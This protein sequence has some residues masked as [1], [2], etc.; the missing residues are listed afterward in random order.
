MNL[1]KRIS[2]VLAVIF[3]FNMIGFQTSF[4]ENASEA[5]MAPQEQAET[6]IA[7][8]GEEL[9]QVE[10]ENEELDNDTISETNTTL[11]FTEDEDIVQLIVNPDE[12]SG[13]IYFVS[14]GDQ[15]VECSED[16]VAIFYNVV[17]G[18]YSVNVRK[19]GADMPNLLASDANLSLSAAVA[20]NRIIEADDA[21]TKTYILYANDEAYY[22]EYYTYYYNSEKELRAGDSITLISGAGVYYDDVKISGFPGTITFNYGGYNTPAAGCVTSITGVIG[23]GY[24]GGAHDFSISASVVDYG[25]SESGGGLGSL[26]NATFN[27]RV[28]IYS[29]F[30]PT[31]TSAPRPTPRPTATP[32]PTPTPDAVVRLSPIDDAQIFNE[33]SNTNKNYGS[34]EYGTAKSEISD[35]VISGRCILY[36]FDLLQVPSEGIT[37]A[38][39]HIFHRWGAGGTSFKVGVLPDGDFNNN[40]NESSITYDEF[41]ESGIDFNDVE[42]IYTGNTTATNPYVPV[43]HKIPVADCLNSEKCK[44]K[45]YVTFVVYNEY[46]PQNGIDFT[47]KEW[48]GGGEDSTN[49]PNTP[50]AYRPT[51]SVNYNYSMQANLDWISDYFRP[52]RAIM[53]DIDLPSETDLG[54]SVTWSTSNASRL[55]NN[56]QVSRPG[57]Y[58]KDAVVTLTAHLTLADGET[59]EKEVT[60]IV[61]R[62]DTI[63]PSDDSQIWFGDGRNS[64]N[65]SNQNYAV[66]KIENDSSGT[67]AA[68]VKG[69]FA[70]YK[71]DLDELAAKPGVE[72]VVLSL[73]QINGASGHPLNIAILGGADAS[74]A[75]TESS[76]TYSSLTQSG[77]DFSALKP[78]ATVSSPGTGQKRFSVDITDAVIDFLKLDE[79][80]GQLTIVV[81]SGTNSNG[82]YSTNGCDLATKEYNDESHRPRLTVESDPDAELL[83]AY[84]SAYESDNGIT[85]NITLPEGLNYGSS[86]SWTTSNEYYIDTD[87]TVT[88]PDLYGSDTYVTLTAALK[89]GNN[90]YKLNYDIKVL[91]DPTLQPSTDIPIR[92][93]GFEYDQIYPDAAPDVYPEIESVAMSVID[94]ENG[95]YQFTIRDDQYTCSQNADPFFFWSAR[96]GTFLPVEGY[97]DYRSVRFTIDPDALDKNVK[98][99]VGIGDS[100][101]YV[102]KKSILIDRDELSASAAAVSEENVVS[103]ALNNELNES[104]YEAVESSVSL[105]IGLD[106]SLAMLNFDPSESKNWVDSING[107]IDSTTNTNIALVTNNSMGYPV[108]KDSAKNSVD[109]IASADYSG[110]TDAVRL[111]DRCVEALNNEEKIPQTGN[112]AVVITVQNITDINALENKISEA[113][114]AGISVYVMALSN[115]NAEALSQIEGVYV[116]GAALELRLNIAELYGEFNNIAQVMSMSNDV[117]LTSNEDK[118]IYTSDYRTGE[119]NF[120][121]ARSFGSDIASVLNM[122]GCLPLV[123]SGENDYNV[124]STVT[125]GQ[126]ILDLI[127]GKAY[128]SSFDEGL[129]NMI[130]FYDALKSG[131]SDSS[132]CTS[133]NISSPEITDMLDRNLKYSFPVVAFSDEEPNEESDEEPNENSKIITQKVEN[134]SGAVE[135]LDIDG[136]A[137][138]GEWSFIDTYNYFTEIIGKG[139]GIVDYVSETE[140]LYD[141][142]RFTKPSGYTGDDAYAYIYANNLSAEYRINLSIESENYWIKSPTADSTILRSVRTD[143]NGVIPTLYNTNNVYII[144]KY[145]DVKDANGGETWYY[146]SLFKATNLGIV[147][148]DT[149]K[150][151]PE[152]QT[153]IEGD[154]T[155]V[156]FNPE[157]PV[158]RAEFLKMLLFSAGFDDIAIYGE[159]VYWAKDVV[160]KAIELALIRTET[161]GNEPNESFYEAPIQRYEAAYALYKTYI[162]Q[163]SEI[164][165]PSNLYEYNEN[166]SCERNTRW[167][168]SIAFTEQNMFANQ[169]GGATTKIAGVNDSD[170]IEGIYQMYLNGVMEGDENREFGTLRSLTKAEAA[171]ILEK[172]LFTLDEGLENVD[173]VYQGA[174][175]YI[176][177]SLQDT[178][179]INQDGDENDSKE[180]YFAAPKTGYYYISDLNNCSVTVSDM[181]KR[182][183]K[184]L[185][186]SSGGARYNI[187]KDETAY[188]KVTTTESSYSFTISVPDDE[189]LVF[190]PDRSA[191]FIYDNN[192]E[193]IRRENVV[194]I[195]DSEVSGRSWLMTNRNLKPGKYIIFSSHNN[196]TYYDHYY[197]TNMND[198]N[199]SIY[200]DALITSH[201]GATVTLN[202]AGYWSA[203]GKSLS[204]SAIQAFSDFSGEDINELELA[205]GESMGHTTIYKKA[206]PYPAETRTNQ[207]VELVFDSSNDCWLSSG[208]QSMYSNEYIESCDESEPL[209]FIAEI[210]VNGDESSYIDLNIGALRKFDGTTDISQVRYVTGTVSDGEFVPQEQIKGVSNTNNIVEADLS[211]EI[212][213]TT[214]YLPIKTSNQYTSYQDKILSEN[215]NFITHGAP[216]ADDSGAKEFY[217]E[218]DML[219][220][221]YDG[222]DYNIYDGWLLS[223]GIT[224]SYMLGNFG[225]KNVYNIEIKNN[226]QTAKK[227]VYR[228]TTATN[229][230]AKLT[231]VINGQRTVQGPF[232]RNEVEYVAGTDSE[233]KEIKEQIKAPIDICSC[234]LPANSVTNVILE[235]WSPTNVLGSLEN[236]F[237]IEDN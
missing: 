158:S 13:Y 205:E 90:V 187:L 116:C 78:V 201:N 218:N 94:E 171:K 166:V 213:D 12:E 236:R 138:T 131:F 215:D 38:V 108:D 41:A 100:L 106:T 70:M 75:W 124:F 49:T 83:N 155:V 101:G 169:I 191:T 65:Y 217:V 7:D 29:D 113:E 111:I 96:Q 89:Q 154:G 156:Y 50:E 40:W 76:V 109:F 163:R 62:E 121:T 210:T 55:T 194:N 59:A 208:I 97:D 27:I 32:I 199:Y 230:M 176:D 117:S 139:V 233:G 172:S 84:M 234:T 147:G 112:K 87:G 192:H 91:Q 98:V 149:G 44:G 189:A 228:M 43:E 42:V 170:Y 193:S 102:D 93:I 164:T 202:N 120:N 9:E 145:E 128:Q 24:A 186:D 58:E 123:V 3:L 126:T 232:A 130:G 214:T 114:S 219:R 1:K 26:G 143:F 110:T 81:Y 180:F 140:K 157:K 68:G 4:A 61:K 167:K 107:L 51:L 127:R 141:N 168:S 99:V 33:E 132:L 20:A 196:E 226:S 5:D 177:F 57:F 206:N 88:R 2:A 53:G 160:N 204:W 17:A 212:D 74:K 79:Y 146:Q 183:I 6:Q 37:D 188:V 227:F 122:Y 134:S 223:D 178:H 46:M 23:S 36:K 181:K 150:Y 184:G 71:F 231:S 119:H 224:K 73:S 77:F 161:T 95:V 174:A 129:S 64:I 195:S 11:T 162:K 179:T 144:K 92:S 211:Y 137:V 203:S 54:A 220:F 39:L 66:V 182:E 225:V 209:F 86:V 237:L 16:G 47:T 135:Y 60:V 34:W 133:G 15:E 175:N 235:V 153:T 19:Q 142:I 200:I 136:T 31:P 45:A 21:E 52:Y 159:D 222:Y 72:R 30:K 35:G 28:Y 148:G 14:L 82:S 80:D 56:G 185:E 198:N 85:G 197:D 105:A 67:G 10:L 152:T 104:D 22:D 173:I 165:V 8:D 207:E 69:R 151:D 221:D 229:Y 216:N 103:M 115:E 63:L 190:A 25:N 118:I 48:N 18:E 125:S